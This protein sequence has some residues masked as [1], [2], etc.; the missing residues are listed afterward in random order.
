M[1]RWLKWCFAGQIFLF[2]LFQLWFFPQLPKKPIHFDGMFY[3]QAAAG[4]LEQHAYLHRGNPTS[5]RPPLY[6]M[7]MSAVYFIFGISINAVRY[8]QILL[9]LISF[10]LLFRFG[11]R[12][13][14]AR[15][16]AWA[17]ILFLWYPPLLLN[18]SRIMSENLFIPLLLAGLLFL[19]NCEKKPRSGFIA[20]LFL[21]GVLLTRSSI[22][23]FIP[24]V[25]IYM[26]I[27]KIDSL[28]KATLWI[29]LGIFIVI[30]PWT[31]RN[32]FVHH[33]FV[34]IDTNCSHVLEHQTVNSRKNTQRPKLLP[35]KN[36][37]R[38]LENTLGS[39][40]KSPPSLE[41][42]SHRTRMRE[43]RQYLIEHPMEYVKKIGEHIGI[44]MG[45]ADK[46][47]RLFYFDSIKKLIYFLNPL[48]KIMYFSVFLL[49]MI[50]L[51]WSPP[52]KTKNY[53]ILF[54]LSYT[55]VHFLIHS[56]SRY[57]MPIMP[58]LFL[59]VPPSINILLNETGSLM[60]RSWKNA[61]MYS[62][63]VIFFI[64]FYRQY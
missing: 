50:G 20:G 15:M 14:S 46:F 27:Q 18:S 45:R 11:I 36:L 54:L 42:E 37:H 32:Y 44:F 1:P 10:W 35:A 23:L 55:L 2:I 29:A 34:L 12:E 4:L 5:L 26:L 17:C 49:S 53:V 43:I 41:I 33:G 22:I 38:N 19:V 64:C 39:K 25:L 13:F 3:H 56:L 61:V 60:K 30:F 24:A 52:S 7:F 8:V 48:H 59:Y 16:T 63:L 57:R 28:R 31:I 62:I 51:T 9:H 6:P 58:F 40:Q 47:H 21:G